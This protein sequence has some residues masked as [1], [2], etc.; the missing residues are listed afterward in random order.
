MKISYFTGGFKTAWIEQAA[1]EFAQKYEKYSFEAGKEGVE[2]WRD[3][4][5][6]MMGTIGANMQAG[7]SLRDLYFTTGGNV[8]DLITKDLVEPIN[9]VYQAKPDGEN[10]KTIREKVLDIRNVEKVYGDG[11]NVYSLPYT[12]AI[13]G[14]VFDY[15]LFVEKEWL[16]FADSTDATDLQAQGFTYTETTNKYGTPVLVMESYTGTERITYK[17]GDVILKAGKDGKFGSHDDGQPQNIEEWN[18]MIQLISSA[19]RTK[20]F[21][22]TNK[23]ADYLDPIAEAIFAQYDGIENYEITYDYDGTYVSPST[24]EETPITLENG[25]KVWEF[26]GR[27]VALEFMKDYLA[28]KTNLHPAISNDRTAMEVQEE[29]V[30]GYKG[31]ALNPQ[32]GMI[33]EGTWWENEVRGLCNELAAAGE[34]DRGYGARD[35]RYMLYPAFENQKGIDGNGNGTV[36]SSFEDGCILV[37]KGA[38]AGS[39]AAAKKFILLS[40]SITLMLSKPRTI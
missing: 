3:D 1:T 21:I 38:K 27:K 8:Q 39:K 26:E 40:L 24:G 25:Y 16:S 6:T 9:D 36:F 35:Y 23:Q 31:T 10:G 29:Y 22:Y 30:L 28:N 20:A 37:R 18:T 12:Q 7:T 11:T 32:A 2:V 34:K 17:K 15:Q 13:T 4:N 33:V 5:K 19:E 14:L